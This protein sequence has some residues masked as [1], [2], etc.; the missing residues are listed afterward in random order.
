MLHNWSKIWTLPAVPLTVWRRNI[1]DHY[2]QS[3]VKG[4]LSAWHSHNTCRSCLAVKMEKRASCRKVTRDTFDSNIKKIEL[5]KLFRGRQ[6]WC[7]TICTAL[8]DSLHI[9]ICSKQSVPH[10][11]FPVIESSI[12]LML[13]KNI[14]GEKSLNNLLYDHTHKNSK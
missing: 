6:E 5:S 12:N 10:F 9:C 7:T 14:S 11:F 2:K 8:W 13:N 4:L 3:S 1:S